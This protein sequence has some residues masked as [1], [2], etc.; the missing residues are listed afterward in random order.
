MRRF[1]LL[2]TA[3]EKTRIAMKFIFALFPAKFR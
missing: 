2:A 3:T 1:L